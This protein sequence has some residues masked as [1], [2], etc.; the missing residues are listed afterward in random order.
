MNSG[1]DEQ[2]LLKLAM[3][4]GRKR[5]GNR[6]I[7]SRSTLRSRRRKGAGSLRSKVMTETKTTKVILKP[8]QKRKYLKPKPGFIASMMFHMQ[9][10]EEI[11]GTNRCQVTREEIE[12][13]TGCILDP[14]MG[15]TSITEPCAKCGSGIS[16]CPGH[17]GYI[18]LASPIYNPAMMKFDVIQKILSI[19]CIH[20]YDESKIEHKKFVDSKLNAMP[21]VN[22]PSS[23]TAEEEDAYVKAE[24]Q[25][26][27]DMINSLPDVPKICIQPLFDE[28]MVLLKWPDEVGIE[29]LNRIYKI[30]KKR[31]CPNQTEPI[32]YKSKEHFI[33]EIVGKDGEEVLME[34][35]KILDFFRA[36]DEDVD[37]NGEPKNWASILGLGDNKLRSFVMTHIP[38]LPNVLRP[39]I[40]LQDGKD[41]VNSLSTQYS[42]IV[43]LNNELK[44]Y[45]RTGSTISS[46]DADAQLDLE[47]KGKR[48]RKK[49]YTGSCRDVFD[50]L[51]RKYTELFF[52][53][54]DSF[55]E[56]FGYTGDVHLL[57]LKILFDGKK[58]QFRGEILGKRADHGARSVIIGNPNLDVDEIGVPKTISEKITIPEPIRDEGDVD[59]WSPFL[60]KYDDNMEIVG[61]IKEIIRNKRRIHVS[62]ETD[63]TLQIGDVIR[64]SMRD[65]DPVVASRQPVLHKGGLMAFRAKLVDGEAI[66]LSPLVTKPFGADFD[67]DEM[68]LAIP[69]DIY[70]RKEVMD[71][72]LASR[73]I[74]GDGRSSP[75]IG[76]IQNNIIAASRVTQ[77]N[78]VVR[79]EVFNEMVATAYNLSNTEESLNEDYDETYGGVFN[80]ITEI[81]KFRQ[82][83]SKMGIK[84]RSGRSAIS[85]LLP[86]KFNYMRRVKGGEDVDIF[87]GVI[88][89]GVLISKDVGPSSRGMIDF[90]LDQYGAKITSV[91]ISRLNRAL[92]V[93]LDEVGFSVGMGDCVLPTDKSI[94]LEPRKTIK[95]LIDEA[96]KQINDLMDV[97]LTSEVQVQA[98]ER[99]IRGILSGIR[100]RVMKVVRAGGVDI[101]FVHRQLSNEPKNA[102]LLETLNRFRD[103]GAANSEVDEL[104]QTL[105]QS[106]PNRKVK[107]IQPEQWMREILVL[108][109]I[110]TY[111]FHLKTDSEEYQ[112]VLRKSEAAFSRFEVLRAQYLDTLKDSINFRKQLIGAD[113]FDNSL[114]QIIYSGAKGSEMNMLQI[115]GLLGQQEIKGARIQ[116]GMAFERPLSFFERN[117]LDVEARGF[118]GKSYGSGVEPLQFFLAAKAA[119]DNIVESNLKPPET[120]HFYR[121]CYTMM[122]DVVASADG[123]VRDENGT[124]IQ[125]AY[126]T[127]NFDARRVIH[128]NGNEQFID[129][130]QTVRNIRVQAGLGEFGFQAEIDE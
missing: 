62:P 100:D 51:N 48:G 1:S 87:N 22:I 75:W 85:F 16:R 72:M 34:E 44:K 98:R 27:I 64:R 60:P 108:Q 25:K 56:D 45:L 86:K 7:S 66:E 28:D 110:S 77:P 130:S 54:G 11:V 13:G 119:R 74:R 73:C 129:V 127:D 20:D 32:T 17:P 107:N 89:S 15:A 69:Q 55:D 31:K 68:N 9:T 52:N 116:P 12:V 14:L 115:A 35:I 90:M 26:R 80:A 61:D 49:V 42:V 120:G 71:K 126:G 101:V 79:D 40:M 118:I 123:T 111:Y 5:R 10:P 125:F 58:G 91:F 21:A 78:V 121:K 39:Q 33:Y 18:K 96:L 30:A 2:A 46:C 65:G 117:T 43:K 95:N 112:R 29:R 99:E 3:Q 50:K 113:K 24:N 23:I 41:K 93:W 109:E 106:A 47:F 103:E 76:L 57:S 102:L 128:V 83:L 124:V 6:Q 38:V 19:F 94:G 84:S 114:L 8:A 53:S 67:G 81:T 105:Q 70:T 104:I 88:I 97:E 92:K 36:I 4:Q 82:K 122:E 37:E 63:V 59:K